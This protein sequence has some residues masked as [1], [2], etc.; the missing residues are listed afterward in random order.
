MTPS[1]GSNKRPWRIKYRTSTE[2]GA[3]RSFLDSE[4][5]LELFLHLN[6]STF[7][8]L[9]LSSLHKYARRTQRT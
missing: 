4:D 3:H 6:Q 5:T 2:L 8:P 1:K 7:S 9:I